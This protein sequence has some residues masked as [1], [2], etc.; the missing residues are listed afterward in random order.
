MTKRE[1]IDKTAIEK[2]D[3]ILLSHLFDL[4]EKANSREFVTSSGFLDLNRLSMA[5]GIE[6]HFKCQNV[7]FGGYEDAERK[8]MYFLPQ[9]DMQPDFSD[10]RVLCSKISTPLNHR[11][12]LGSLMGLGIDRSLVGDI[13]I[14]EKSVQIIVKKEIA[15][16]IVQNFLRASKTR[17]SFEVC[18]IENI[19][20]PDKTTKEITGTIKSLRLDSVI[21]LAFSVSRTLCKDLIAASKVFVND[22]CVTKPDLI[23]SEG[24]KLTLRGKGKAFLVEIGSLSRK[25][26]IFVKIQRYI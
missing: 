15:Q 19:E 11:E 24:D 8:V 10:I 22:R 3:K 20:I 9:G 5:E 23:V 16:F 4:D 26:R 1:I 6:K 18:D 21:S 14:S 17:L 12:V 25:E 7:T 2:E 13:L